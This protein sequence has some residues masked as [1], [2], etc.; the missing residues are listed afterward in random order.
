MIVNITHKT[1][2]EHVQRKVNV[3]FP[4]L[5]IEFSDK[6][7]A[8][9]QKTKKA[10]WYDPSFKLLDIAK[11]QKTGWVTLHPWDKTGFVEEI[12]ENRFGLH[13]QIFRKE[14]DQWIETAGTDV[15]TLEEQN[16]IGRKM[17]DKNRGVY[18][19]ESELLL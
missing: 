4:F 17:I 19:R 2:I 18:R 14:N 6:A 10:H 11:K 9:G 3:A 12:F 7:H 13:A 5:K 16:E 8:Q 1:T 15:F